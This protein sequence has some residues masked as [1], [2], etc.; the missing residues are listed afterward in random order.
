MVTKK[1]VYAF[2]TG[3]SS[4]GKGI[5]FFLCSP[6]GS[7]TI[8]MELSCPMTIVGR[9]SKLY[10]GHS[11]P[12]MP[13]SPVC[14]VHLSRITESAVNAAAAGVCRRAPL[15]WCEG[16][17]SRSREFAE[18]VLLPSHTC[19]LRSSIPDDIEHRKRSSCQNRENVPEI[20]TG[21]AAVNQQVEAS[22]T[23]NS[24]CNYPESAQNRDNP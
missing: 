2:F 12:S 17:W 9:V 21:S 19:L 22:V 3:K 6:F 16:S 11:N 20:L 5:S 7:F 18:C 14:F 10:S 24:P 1:K 4:S 8:E 15:G 13:G 23:G